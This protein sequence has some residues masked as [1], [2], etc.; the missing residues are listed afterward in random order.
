M[1]VWDDRILA[2]TSNAPMAGNQNEK[3]STFRGDI[4]A[5]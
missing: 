2:T 5:H 1:P 3:S 4:P